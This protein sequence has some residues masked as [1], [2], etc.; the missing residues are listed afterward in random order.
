MK[1]LSSFEKIIYWNRK[2][3]IYIGLFFLLFILFFSLSGLLLNHSQWKFAS[4]WKERKETEN[5]IHVTLPANRDSAALIQYF[6]KQFNMSGE[7]SNVRLTDESI[8]FRVVKPGL[9]QEINADL[10]SGTGVRKEIVF[11]WWGKIRNLHTFNGSDKEHPEIRPNWFVTKIWRLVMD[12]VALG[13]IF[14]C[15]SGW[16]MWYKIRKSYTY[17]LIVLLLGISGAIFFVFVMRML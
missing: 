2:F 4:F 16:I 7:I 3:H 5:T 6:M 13:L 15:I 1:I 12:A 10:K 17:G 11:N 9:M 8:H 14:L